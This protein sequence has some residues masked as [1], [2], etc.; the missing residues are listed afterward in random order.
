MGPASLRCQLPQDG[1]RLR[2]RAAHDLG[3][4]EN[5]V[6]EPDRLPGERAYSCPRPA[7]TALTM[8]GP[9][10]PARADSSS[11]RPDHRREKAVGSMRPRAGWCGRL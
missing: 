1:R 2:A 10:S 8:A 9:S 11:G 4:G 5:I 6:D 7:S 3:G